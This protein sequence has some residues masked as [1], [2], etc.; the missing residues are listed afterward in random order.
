MFLAESRLSQSQWGEVVEPTVV[1]KI[2]EN[3]DLSDITIMVERLCVTLEQEAIAV[4]IDGIGYLVYDPS[5]V[6]ERHSYNEEYFI[7]Y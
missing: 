3:W 6:G 4:K 7:N 1:S 2:T 5:Y